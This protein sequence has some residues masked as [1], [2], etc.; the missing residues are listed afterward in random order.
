MSMSTDDVDKQL[1]VPLEIPCVYYDD[2]FLS[3]HEANRLYKDLQASTPWTK[4]AKINRWVALYVDDSLQEEYKYRD[5]SGGTH[6]GFN[7]SIQLLKNKAQDWYLQKTG[8]SVDFNVCLLNYYEDGQQRIGWHSDR[9]EVGRT[10]PIA[11]I[12]L[13]ANRQFLLRS[14][15]NG[16]HDRATLDLENG[17][18]VL[19]ENE[20]QLK[21]VHSVPRQSDVLNGRINLTFRCKQA[22]ETTAGE[23]EHERRDTILETLTDGAVPDASAWSNSIQNPTQAQNLFGNDATELEIGDCEILYLVKTNLGTERF[24]AAEIQENLNNQEYE[25]VSRPLGLDGFVAVCTFPGEESSST[26]DVMIRSTLLRLRSAHHVLKYHSHFHLQEATTEEFPAPEKVDGETLY[27]YVKKRLVD[28]SLKIDSLD[29]LGKGTFRCSCERLGGP[30]A[31]TAPNV[32]YEVGGAISEYYTNIKPKM[33]DY[34]ICVRADLVGNNVVITTQLNTQDLSKDR[35]FLKFR[36][37]VTIK[38]N[39]AYVMVRLANLKTGDHVLDPFCGSGTLLLEAMEVMKKQVTCTGM[40]VSRRSAEG[41]RE[42][43]IEAGFNDTMC[44]FVC[45]DAR[46]LRKHISDDS[47]DAIVS[48]LPWGVVTGSDTDLQTMYE[49]FLRNSW[50]VMKSG[51][52]IVMLVLRGLLVTRIARKLAGRF[53]LLSVTVVRTTN[54]LPCLIVLEKLPKDE[55]RDSIKGQLA[56]LNQYV[57]VS[58]DIY[59]AIHNE[60]I[61]EDVR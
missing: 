43:A 56:Y 29:A 47:V 39:I 10:T 27:Q 38:T 60:D 6:I 35:H 44:K 50:Y 48:N 16:I 7:D 9:E 30:H 23:E 25:V 59:H 54:N 14:K 41:S 2:K 12:S 21:Y 53:R 1:L 34:D 24:C 33:E 17:S 49:I 55:V 8:I 26:D 58:P 57:S 37:A 46:G 31:F 18:L 42:N 3:S 40:D 4:T 11:S 22:N 20:C 61:D 52:R 51:S 28:R 13:G 45:S 32:E 5:A 19:M 15:E 36:N